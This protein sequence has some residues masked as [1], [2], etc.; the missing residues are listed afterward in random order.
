MIGTWSGAT[1]GEAPE[2]V[3]LRSSVLVGVGAEGF[4]VEWQLDQGEGDSPRRSDCD[5]G[6]PET[7]L[8]EK[9]PREKDRS[10]IGAEKTL[11]T[12]VK[13]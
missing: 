8:R 11:S 12:T 13:N 9:A 7:V 2:V 1:D 5:Q 4:T 6:N 3:D 10:R